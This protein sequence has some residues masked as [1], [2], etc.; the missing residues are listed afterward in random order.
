MAEAG[1]IEQ[2]LAQILRERLRTG[3]ADGIGRGRRARADQSGG[4]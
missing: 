1:V 3:D 4:G 2:G